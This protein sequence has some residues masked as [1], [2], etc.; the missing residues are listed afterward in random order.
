MFSLIQKESEMYTYCTNI[1]NV[2][3]GQ[4]VKL[5]EIRPQCFWQNIMT[6]LTIYF[7]PSSSL[8]WSFLIIFSASSSRVAKNVLCEVPDSLTFDLRNQIRSPSCP[9]K[10]LC[11]IW[12]NSPQG[13]H[14]TRR[15]WE[16]DGGDALR[17]KTKSKLVGK[18]KT[19]TVNTCKSIIIHLTPSNYAN[20]STYR[21]RRR[22]LSICQFEWD[23]FS[24]QNKDIYIISYIY[25]YIYVCA[26]DEK[27][28]QVWEAAAASRCDDLTPA[29]SAVPA[30]AN[31]TSTSGIR[32]PSLWQLHF[33][34]SHQPP[35]FFRWEA[36]GGGVSSLRP[37]AHGHEHF[38]IVANRCVVGEK[39][40]EKGVCILQ[41]MEQLCSR[42]NC[43]C[44]A[45]PQVQ[46]NKWKY[47]NQIHYVV[48]NT[49]ASAANHSVS[50]R[51]RE[52]HARRSTNLFKP[53]WTHFWVTGDVLPQ[54]RVPNRKKKKERILQVPSLRQWSSRYLLKNMTATEMTTASDGYS[55]NPW[56]ARNNKSHQLPETDTNSGNVSPNVGKSSS[57]SSWR[58]MKPEKAGW[59]HLFPCFKR[60]NQ[61]I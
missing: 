12:R 42:T 11:Q 35:L 48:V 29:T 46:M 55:V 1:P 37:R 38:W 26:A 34:P 21:N 41:G 15:P 24:T 45:L 32:G 17:L 14:V 57:N 52:R 28:Y 30:W 51:A 40:R 33:L 36:G 53:Q 58:R 39:K 19:G 54:Q 49:V 18:S 25:I 22:S 10:G 60:R 47:E 59:C 4:H 9:S 27:H 13:V 2:C 3:L 56:D 43:L 50:G 44:N 16:W 20:H 7:T 6:H 23:W 5:K 31:E 61:K 8:V